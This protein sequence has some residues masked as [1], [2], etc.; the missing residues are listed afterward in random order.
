MATD[1][2]KALI[3]VVG[4]RY[5]VADSDLSARYRTDWTGR[6]GG[7]DAVVV[8]PA[9]IDET[10]AVIRIALARGV[11]VV[12]QGGNTGLVGGS[13]PS[14]DGAIILSTERLT[15][16]GALD[17]RAGQITV[18]AGVTLSGL[19]G[20]LEGSGWRFA[21]DLG[22]RDSA[23]I[24]G[25]VAT[26]AG[27]YQVVRY[28]MTRDSVLGL[29]AVLPDGTVV[30]AMNRMLK[31]NAGFDVKQLFIGSEGLLGVVTR[32][33]LRLRAR[34]DA[35]QTA[36][37]AIAG[38]DA[39]PQLLRTLERGLGG[40]LTSFE[41]MGSDYDQFVREHSKQL[42]SPLAPGFPCYVI[43]EATG[44]DATRDRAHFARVLEDARRQGLLATA[45]IARD[46]EER[47][48]IWALREQAGG[49]F[50]KLGPFWAYDVSLPVGDMASYGRRVKQEV[51]AAYPGARLL[52]LGH[53][54]DG[55][56]HLVA[57]PGSRDP[58]VKREV[59]DI[60]YAAVR[61]VGGSVSAEHGIGLE[62]L[63][64]LAWSRTPEEIALMRALKRTMDPL[65]ILNPGKMLATID[66]PR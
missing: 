6:F 29:E 66:E 40:Q 47:A 56:L 3:E 25:M 34:Q 20:A 24:G 43:V 30:R 55:N 2:I 38:D 28:G 49:D 5:V 57:A 33:V 7:H 14:S 13:V 21:V 36:L 9:T 26:N 41:I 42:V 10:S 22:A 15:T 45:S 53:V 18:G 51:T 16:I 31:N 63:G 52:L 62:K 27:G 54:G 32:V 50:H 60:V 8:R 35:A 65:G 4:R 23:T 59:D 11:P 46:E 64:Y 58:A 17:D 37:L 48:E 39:V 61:D 44:S 19:G 12:P 1:L